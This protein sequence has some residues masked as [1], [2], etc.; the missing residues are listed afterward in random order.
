MDKL[1]IDTLA[2][3]NLV[4]GGD[5]LTIFIESLGISRFDRVEI[6][7]FEQGGIK[8][9]RDFIRTMQLA[10][11]F[12]SI[13]LGVIY[14]ADSLSVEAQNALLKLLEE[15]P[16]FAKIIVCAKVESSILLTI[17]SRC[18]RIT[19]I[20]QPQTD[21][22]PEPMS[23]LE[24]FNASEIDAKSQECRA[25]TESQM[26]ATYSSWCKAGRPSSSVHQVEKIW[27]L[28]HNLGT[29]MNKRILLE[30]YVL[31]TQ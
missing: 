8:E 20:T 1:E 26:V 10:P 18:R 29:N 25:K 3:A 30:Q 31:E 12:N 11:Q 27:A 17:Q 14:S 4:I 2:H 28:Y 6:G 22:I 9:V 13:R 19:V 21:L 15:P 24:R 7:P 5:D 16:S 23:A